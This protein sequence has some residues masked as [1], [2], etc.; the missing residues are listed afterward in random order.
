MLG[1]PEQLPDLRQ[2]LQSET[3]PN[4]R[5][6][7]QKAI[8]SLS[9][10]QAVAAPALMEAP[11]PVSL[12]P[13]ETLEPM[14]TPPGALAPASRP[15][16]SAPPA[17]KPPLS[18]TEE[19]LMTQPPAAA[20]LAPKPA[21]AMAAPSKTGASAAPLAPPLA[22]EKKPAAPPTAQLAGPGAAVAAAPG[23]TGAPGLLGLTSPAPAPST[24][25]IMASATP[26]GPI[27]ETGPQNPELAQMI[28]VHLPKPSLA[29]AA[30]GAISPIAA[31]LSAPSATT[32]PVLKPEPVPEMATKAEASAKPKPKAETETKAEAKA[33]PKPAATAKPKAEETEAAK[34]A[35]KPEQA[36]KAEAK[37]KPEET[38][39]AAAA[40][41]E[42]EVAMAK[43]KAEE[44][45]V[46]PKAEEAGGG[47]AGAE[48]T[49]KA[50]PEAK[51]EETPEAKGSATPSPPG[52]P[53]AEEEAKRAPSATPAAAAAKPEV[54]LV[55]IALEPSQL[56]A[57]ESTTMRMT[58]EVTGLAEGATLSV[59]ERR[60]IM[61]DGKELGA[62]PETFDRGNN[63]ITSESKLTVPPD[64]PPGQY[65]YQCKVS[66]G[67]VSSVMDKTFTI[68]P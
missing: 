9:A 27:E 1:S 24:P 50:T 66:M 29:G 12:G 62:W 8:D 15:A 51:A 47:K 32:K 26:R 61:Q 67:D 36:P 57:G 39:K 20:P 6:A 55:E 35:A 63:R 5:D 46:T 14:G 4:V 40:K 21:I 23:T 64:A 19:R 33:T 65:T 37:A 41:A 28:R 60:S 59:I 56:K 68:A 3:A 43:P 16:L 45:T 31:G 42:T 54:R 10:K 38:P 18:E 22:A 30:P 17:L 25:K 7:I 13:K 2:A 52:E 34:A 48:P 11:Q 49:P 53:T 58:Y 44:A